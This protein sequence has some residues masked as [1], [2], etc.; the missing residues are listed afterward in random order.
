MKLEA[1]LR[2]GVYPDPGFGGSGSLSQKLAEWSCDPDGSS[3]DSGKREKASS[4]C[5]GHARN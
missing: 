4:R 3:L 2:T 1:A 5:G